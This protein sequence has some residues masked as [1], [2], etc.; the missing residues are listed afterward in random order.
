MLKE[1]EDELIVPRTPISHLTAR[2]LNLL[3]HQNFDDEEALLVG[4]EDGRVIYRQ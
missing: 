1:E 4:K 3:P 2:L